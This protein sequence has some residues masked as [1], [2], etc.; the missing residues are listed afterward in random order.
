MREALAASSAKEASAVSNANEV[1]AASSTIKA[2]A[3]SDAD[4]VE[5]NQKPVLLGVQCVRHSAV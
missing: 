5:K 1:L 4:A 3:A 2:S